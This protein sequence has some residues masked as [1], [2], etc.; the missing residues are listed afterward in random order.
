[1]NTHINPLLEVI[2][3][4]KYF[5]ITGGFFR[6]KIG[7]VKAVDGVN[8]SI[9]EG[10]TL[11]LV[12]ESGCGKTTVGR[13]IIRLYE[14]TSGDVRFHDPEMGVISIPKLKRSEFMRVRHN[15]QFIFQDPYSSLDP[16]MTVGDIIAEPLRINLKL[17]D[18][19]RK[20]RVAELLE[21]VGMSPDYMTRYPHAFSG[22]QRQRIG[23]ARALSLNPKLIICD[24]PVSALDV[25]IQAQ[26]IN[27]L[28][29]LQQELNLTYLFIAHDL[30]VVEHISNRVSV[31]YVGHLVEMADTQEIF[32]HPRHP[33]T[34][35]LLSS[36]PKTDPLLRDSPKKLPGDVPSPANPPPG[37][38]FHPRCQYAQDV[39]RNESPELRELGED[40]WVACHLADELKLQGGKVVH[41]IQYQFPTLPMR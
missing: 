40:H 11:G 29:D 35:A 3:L 39:C 26:V 6:R 1:M 5:P 18:K 21:M 22:G 32:F 12:G 30:S 37:C 8:F 16:R 25:S 19:D 41:D 14:P 20:D 17:R 28:Q 27:L 4:K 36:I 7:D 33:Y 9:K 34:E 2:G 15:M 38:K 31:M 10:E 23:I 13:T 24:E